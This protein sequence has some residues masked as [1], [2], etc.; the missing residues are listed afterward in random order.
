MKTGNCAARKII[1]NHGYS[2]FCAFR[3][4][5][6]AGYGL[7]RAMQLAGPRRSVGNDDD[8]AALGFDV[9]GNAD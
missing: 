9:V 7:A 3:R 8:C 6:K 4:Y 5:R 1:V 2:F